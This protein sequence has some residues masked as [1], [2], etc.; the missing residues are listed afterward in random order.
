MRDFEA[1]GIDHGSEGVAEQPAI[2]RKLEVL[3][4]LGPGYLELGHAAT[5]LSGGEAQRVK[6]V[7]ELGKMRRGRRNLYILDE[8]TTG[9]PPC[10]HPTPA[11]L[12]AAPRRGHSALV[13]EHHLDVTKFADWIIDLGP[14]GGTRAANWWLQERRGRRCN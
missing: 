14:E 4:E 12:P 5:I 10:R 2:A 11:G 3:H 6:L 7:A 9:C 13:I 1:V 8:P